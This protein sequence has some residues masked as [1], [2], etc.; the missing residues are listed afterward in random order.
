MSIHYFRLPTLLLGSA[1]PIPTDCDLVL[2]LS[3]LTNILQETLQ[4]LRRWCV[5]TSLLMVFCGVTAFSFKT[6]FL[7]LC[8]WEWW[9][10]KCELFGTSLYWIKW[11]CYCF[12]AEWEWIRVNH[13]SWSFI[14]AFLF[15]D[16]SLAVDA[17]SH[18]I[19]INSAER[20]LYP[21]VQEL[22]HSLQV[23]SMLSREVCNP[24]PWR[25]SK[26]DLSPRNLQ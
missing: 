23:C 18:Q 6:C 20:R 14:D 21:S 9:R 11:K 26:L 22:H 25:Y 7:V 8:I 3:K 15:L 24:H 5:F 2:T 4:G 13:R 16:P 1:L 17:T 10:P 19:N 12:W